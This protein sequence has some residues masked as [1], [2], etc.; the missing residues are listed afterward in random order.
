MESRRSI[1]WAGAS[2]SL[3]CFAKDAAKLLAWLC[4]T[5][6]RA[7]ESNVAQKRAAW[8]RHL[9]RASGRARRHG[10]CNLGRRQHGKRSCNASKADARR[11]S[12]AGSE[13]LDLRAHLACCR[14]CLHKSA[15][16]HVQ[17]EDRAIILRAADP[18]CSVELA[19]GVLHQSGERVRAIR[20]S[21]GM[22]CG[23]SALRRD[24]KDCSIDV[25]A[26]RNRCVIEIAVSG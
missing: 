1:R 16:T 10:S 23:Q 15:E 2:I 21:E 5:L 12:E 24:L 22:Q 19:V 25:G 9:H 20:S 3:T 4:A 26:A 8:G 6:V 18:G 17:A 7:L 14:H 11:A 13:N